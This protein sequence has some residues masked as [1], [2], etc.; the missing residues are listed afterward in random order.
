[1]KQMLTIALLAILVSGCSK[2]VTF[3]APDVVT[4]IRKIVTDSMGSSAANRYDYSKITKVK[5]SED[6]VYYLLRSHSEPDAFLAL[7]MDGKNLVRKGVLVTLDREGG[8][9]HPWEAMEGVI[10]VHSIRGNLLLQSRVS[11][12]Y[13]MGLYEKR[14]TDRMGIASRSNV[15]PIKP[16]I[17]VPLSEVIVI[18]YRSEGSSYNYSN[19]ISIQ[20]LFGGGPGGTTYAPIDGGGGS[21]GNRG[22]YET[23]AIRIDDEA[24]VN[25]PPIDVNQYLDC[26]DGL[27]DAGAQCSIELLTDIPVDSDPRKLVDWQAG[28]AGHTFLQLRKQVGGQL[29]VQNIGF[30]PVSSWKVSFTNAPVPGKFVDNSNHEYNASLRMQVGADQFRR[31]LNELRYLARSV[32]YD[33]DEF[34]C[35]DL[36]VRVFNAARNNKLD[37]PLYQIPGGITAG[38]TSTPQGLYQQLKAI[39]NA[40][41]AE[42]ANISFPGVKGYV[43]NSNGP[44][45]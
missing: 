33:L 42:V 1:M 21:H 35:T 30:Y 13:I 20:A 17:Y 44:C 12:G 23:D 9:K 3:S 16:D 7:W 26:F 10:T 8:R 43:A 22:L 11:K 24:A 41:G 40:G 39:Y 6:S 28:S 32:T 18:G 38:G 29:I 31:A 14:P 37:I 2:E 45:K 19:W 5:V 25:L 4:S 27:P 36:A 15:A 34:N